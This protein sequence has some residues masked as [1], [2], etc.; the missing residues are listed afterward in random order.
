[1]RSRA[2]KR[3]WDCFDR[4]PP[5]IQQRARDAYARWSESPYH[6]SLHFGPVYSNRPIY[7]V[8]IGRHW[9]A[10]GAKADDTII[11]YWIGSH[12]EYDRLLA[13]G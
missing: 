9:R 6:P 7:S 11:W 5:E 1:M 12:A 10:L 2:T 4:L 8:R 3:F 13:D